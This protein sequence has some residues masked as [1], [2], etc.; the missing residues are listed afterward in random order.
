MKLLSVILALLSLLSIGYILYWE[1]KHKSVSVFLWATLLFMFGL[2]NFRDSIVGND[3]FGEEVIAEAS[4]FVFLFCCLYLVSRNCFVQ[5]LKIIKKTWSLPKQN[6]SSHFEYIILFLLILCTYLKYD[7]IASSGINFLDSS[8][9]EGREIS[10]STGYVNSTQFVLPVFFLSSGLILYSLILKKRYLLFFS[11]IVSF[12]NVVLT[13]NKVEVLPLLI[14]F[15][16]YELYIKKLTSSRIFLLVL[17]SVMCIYFVYALQVFRHYGSIMQFYLDFDFIDFNKRIY[18]YVVEGKSEIGLYNDF[19]Y[20]I[21]HDNNFK[22]FGLAHSYIRVLLIWLPTG[23]S[24]GIKPPDFAISM[25]LALNPSSLG[26]GESVHPTLF[27]DCYANL[28]FLGGILLAIFWSWVISLI[29]F[30]TFLNKN[31]LYRSL[32]ITLAAS[33]LVISG[34]GA[35]Y[36]SF[37]ILIVG[38]VLLLII[39]FIFRIRFRYKLFYE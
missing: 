13:R 19:Y 25:G 28:N 29:D 4:V 14:G 39:K 12:F 33:F 24:M 26:L 37:Y 5:Y 32:F 10:A 11:I 3:R 22:N 2:T 1:I 20:F 8:W 27:G 21:D 35:V 17:L 30:Y 7:K 31:L 34:R 6:G 38:T 16:Y 36:N 18:T 9:G 15:V 23:W